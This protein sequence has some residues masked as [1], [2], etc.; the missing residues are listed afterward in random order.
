M[1]RLAESAVI[2]SG[3]LTGVQGRTYRDEPEA[4]AGRMK[5]S[6]ASVTSKPPLCGLESEDKHSLDVILGPVPRICNRLILF[7]VIRSSAWGR[8]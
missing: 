8:G 1:R 7:D 2:G 4:T 6:A 3:G 5:L